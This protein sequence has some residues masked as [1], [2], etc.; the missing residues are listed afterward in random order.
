MA[1][2]TDGATTGDVPNEMR[3]LLR[4]NLS[5]RTVGTEE[6][7]ESYRNTFV[8]G[9]GLGAVM[10]L[11]EL[12][13]GTDP[14]SPENPLF[15]TFG[16]LTGHAPGTSRYGVVTKSPLTGTFVDSYSG[17]HF[18]SMFRFAMPSYLGVVFEG[19]ADDPV[20]LRVDDGEV[21][22]ED[23]DHLWG[24]HDARETAREF[25][26][27]NT[28]V[29]AIGPA[30]ENRVRF[31]TISSD[32]ASHHAGRGG[33]GA[34]MGSKNLKAVVATGTKPDDGELQDLRIDHMRRLGNGTET[35]WAREGGTQIIVDWT[36]E[37]GALPSHNWTEG[38]IDD[39][40]TLNIDAF[41]P[42]H[43]RPDSCYNCPIACG[44]V[45]DFAGTDVGGAFPDASVAWG[46]EY[47]TIGMMGANT[48]I[49]DV[50]GVTELADRA[51]RLGM[52]TISL[53]N[54]VS[55]L[56]ETSER[57]IVEFDIEFG[58]AETA[59]EVVEKVAHREGIGDALAEGTVGAAERLCPDDPRAR[60]AAV[61]VKGMELPAYDPRASLSMALAYAT[62]D[63]GGCHQRAFPIGS[64]A[65]GGERDPFDTE[66]HAA[67][68][69]DEQNEGALSFSMVACDFTA[70]NYE[71]V[72]EWL[73][74]FG[75]DLTVD[76][77][78][79][80]G[81]RAWTM[82]RLFNLR[83]GFD[84]EDDSLPERLTRPLESGGPAD[85]NRVTEADFETMLEE[86]YDIRG[87]TEEGVP[88]KATI[89]R[90]DLE[91]FVPDEVEIGA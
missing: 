86:Y 73:R 18:P 16:P 46:P 8:S 48:D 19:S 2:T 9:K 75:Y 81:E 34:V 49:T 85:G 22:I 38:T 7:P 32:E 60:E 68:V 15:F 90:L 76:D 37:V 84:R 77:L 31:A 69:V 65:L 5:E 89:E 50:T 40:D 66:G 74:E 33:V 14:L 63:R 91:P 39:V 44:H 82:T 42:G 11:D 80:V 23:A 10:L 62:S 3:H 78:E 54:V 17:G 57:G 58:D 51:D 47:E 45:T 1:A 25:A 64:D 61:E 6:V 79:T 13:P 87:W 21:S 43:R 27:R 56:M 20:L 72:A 83:E 35:E 28:K 29:A 71:R 26:D 59:A 70:Y 55:W 52:D 36:Q 12:P 41:E 4:V 53:G 30:G 67:A 24:S 88:Q